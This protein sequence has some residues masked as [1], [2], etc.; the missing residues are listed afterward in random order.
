MG[1]CCGATLCDG[2]AGA[3]DGA[4]FW[5][6]FCGVVFEFWFEFWGAVVVGVVASGVTVLFTVLGAT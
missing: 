3:G 1:A 5:F 4:V 6:V 2:V